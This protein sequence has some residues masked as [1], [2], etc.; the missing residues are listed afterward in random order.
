[1]LWAPPYACDLTDHLRGKESVT[2]RLEVSNTTANALAA[3]DTVAGWVADAERWHGRRFRM[4][5]LDRV[6][7][8]LSSG[9]LTVPELV[10]T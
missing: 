6:R 5:A 2:L 1:V 3:D 7:D 9:L 10:R 8:G 4:Q